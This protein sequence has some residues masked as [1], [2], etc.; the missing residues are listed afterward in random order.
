MFRSYSINYNLNATIDDGSCLYSGCTDIS[1]I[2]YDSTATLDD[3][4][5]LYEESNVEGYKLFWNDEFNLDSLNLKFW[6]IEELWP[7]AF[8]EESQSYEK[9]RDNIIVIDG[10]LYIRARKRDAFRP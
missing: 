7:G 5:C 9:N 3:E 8:N 6:N 10:K 4:N 1:A 2:N